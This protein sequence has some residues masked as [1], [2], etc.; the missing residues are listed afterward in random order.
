M[1]YQL[2]EE[3]NKGKFTFTNYRFYSQER[4]RRR[5]SIK[6]VV[7]ELENFKIEV[8]RRYANSTLNKLYKF[9]LF[10][11]KKVHISNSKLVKQKERKIIKGISISMSQE[12]KIDRITDIGEIYQDRS[13]SKD[14]NLFDMAQNI[15]KGIHNYYKKYL[16]TKSDGRNSE[17]PKEFNTS[18]L[19]NTHSDL[20][21]NNK[22]ESN[23]IE[24]V[25]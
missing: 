15:S 23:S 18:L 3:G 6:R 9:P 14:E 13:R 17:L 7:K 21:K 19:K 2:K 8:Q 5:S 20:F 10:Q 25:S 11:Q 24:K 22:F 12:C 16:V 1:A 4:Q